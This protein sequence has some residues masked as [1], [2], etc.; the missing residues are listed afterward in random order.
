[1]ITVATCKDERDLQATAWTIGFDKTLTVFDG[2][3]IVAQYLQGY[4][5]SVYH[6]E[7][8]RGCRKQ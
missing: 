4:W 1:M 2:S 7:A 8:L 5:Q 6:A 3:K